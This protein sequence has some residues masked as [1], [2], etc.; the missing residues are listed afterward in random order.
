MAFL[1][2]IFILTKGAKDFLSSTSFATLL[3]MFLAYN[4]VRGFKAIP[5]PKFIE[6]LK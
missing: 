3:R 6:N 4:N 5:I 2:C 1:F